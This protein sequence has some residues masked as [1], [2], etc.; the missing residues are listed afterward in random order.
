M[1]KEFLS[2][3]LRGLLGA[4]ER[5]CCDHVDLHA[6]LGQPTGHL[7]KSLDAF[8][9]QSARE[10]GAILAEILRP[11]MPCDVEMAGDRR[12]GVLAFL[13][14]METACNPRHRLSSDCACSH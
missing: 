2:E 6:R 1:L 8:L 9:G 3:D 14:P 7:A 12:H 4:D 13:V 5:A 10:V 11:G